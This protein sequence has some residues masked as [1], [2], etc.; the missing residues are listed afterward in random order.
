MLRRLLTI[1]LARS[2]RFIALGLATL[3]TVWYGIAQNTPLLSG[4]AGFFTNANA[5]QTTYSPM[6]QPLLAAP[7]GQHLLI[8]SRAVPTEAV[9]PATITPTS[10]A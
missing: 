1:R 6:T 3:S 9:T 5:G 4:G 8:E 2:A 10:S 7:I